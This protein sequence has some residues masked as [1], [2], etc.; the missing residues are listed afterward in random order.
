MT[1]HASIAPPMS[2]G[3]SI[4]ENSGTP[5]I[6]DGGN[7][8]PARRNMQVKRVTLTS[9]KNW[10]MGTFLLALFLCVCLCYYSGNG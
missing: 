4:N 8:T 7:L 10:W 5:M 1:Q 9:K 3:T 6:L 2:R